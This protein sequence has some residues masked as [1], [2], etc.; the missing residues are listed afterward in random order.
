MRHARSF[1]VI[2]EDSQR[3]FLIANTLQRKFPHSVVQ[4]CRD[5]P[6]AVAIVT[7]QPLDAIV[8]HRSADMDEIPLV[9][10]L[11]AVTTVPIVLMTSAALIEKALHAGA[12]RCVGKEQWL[13]IGTEVAA[14]IGATKE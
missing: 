11:R 9:E 5:S 10:C 7:S 3:L 6:A 12:S 2:A 8:A 14:T 4:T 13:L 1:L